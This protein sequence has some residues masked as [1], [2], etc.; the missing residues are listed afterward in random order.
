[1]A[2][3]TEGAFKH[4]VIEVNL[5]E[6]EYNFIKWLS[7]RDDEKYSRELELMFYTELRAL[8]DLYQEEMIAEGNNS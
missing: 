5:T 3:K 2:K 4:S 6:E 1:M 8:Q 7:K